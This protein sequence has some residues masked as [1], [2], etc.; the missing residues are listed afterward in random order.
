MFQRQNFGKRQTNRQLL[1]E[2]TDELIFRIGYLQSKH[3]YYF[4]LL[5]ELLICLKL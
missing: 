1:D 3:M 2:T 5:K 4:L